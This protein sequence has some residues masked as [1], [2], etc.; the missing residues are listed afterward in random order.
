MTARP[1]PLRRRRYVILLPLLVLLS[2][3][4]GMSHPPL[5]TVSHVDLQRF[6][7]DW[8]VIAS[9]PTRFEVGAYNAVENY[10]LDADGSIPTTFTFLDGGFDGKK[11]SYTS[12]AFVKD[13]TTNATWGVQ[14]IWPFR[15]DYRIIDLSADYQTVIVAR[16]KRDYAWIMAR[17][18]TIDRAEYDRLIGRLAAV[19]YDTSLVQQVPQRW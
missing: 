16:Q 5:A 6:M 12:R 18:P 4:Q 9:I 2:G 13:T 19:G 7:G 15:A 11:K 10:R 3:C 8:Y 1:E 14:F 17:T